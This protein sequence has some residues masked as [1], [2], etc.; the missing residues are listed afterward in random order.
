M[1]TSDEGDDEVETFEDINMSFED[2]VSFFPI[3][4]RAKILEGYWEC[5]ECDTREFSAEEVI[6]IQRILCPFV[7]LA[8]RCPKTGTRM[9]QSVTPRYPKLRFRV[10][11]EKEFSK[12]EKS[13]EFKGVDELIKVWPH[14]V[15]TQFDQ[16]VEHGDVPAFLAG[17]RL[18]MI[19]IVPLPHG[20]KALECKNSRTLQLIQLPLDYGGVFCEVEDPKGYTLQ[21]LV[22]IAKVP[23]IL[24]IIQ[25]SVNGTEQPIPISGIPAGFDDYLEMEKPALLVEINRVEYQIEETDEDVYRNLLV[26]IDCEIYLAPRSDTYRCLVNK[27]EQ[28]KKLVIESSNSFPF[29]ARIT[30]WKEETTVLQNHVTRPGDLLLFYSNRE[31]DKVKKILARF[32]QRYFLI[33]TS[34]E[35]NFSRIAAKG[36]DLADLHLDSLDEDSSFPFEVEYNNA[37]PYSNIR[38]CLLPSDVR[39]TFEAFVT[40]Q[41]VVVSKLFGD[42]IGQAF[43]LPLRTNLQVKFERRWKM[44]L[45]KECTEKMSVFDW[46]AEEIVGTMY[47]EIMKD[48]SDYEWL[49]A[50][51]IPQANSL[52]APNNQPSGGSSPKNSPKERPHAKR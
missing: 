16:E 26:P 8:F 49:V 33:P 19:R 13:R 7:R 5:G 34:H 32:E 12:L 36:K 46:H 31:E 37:I 3:P 44:R 17:D 39:L 52:L 22:D 47:N 20:E 42:T 21:E 11:T 38:D 4:Q 23:R 35:G 10:V 29:I 9:S 15:E 1:A 30:G 48:N 27:C 50:P 43:H 45:P 24:K 2:F 14:V 28:L 41:S 51:P 6:D 25:N 18:R 40:E